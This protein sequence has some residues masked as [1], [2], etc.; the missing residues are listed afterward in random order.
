MPL[1]S[2]ILET[3]SLV[4]LLLRGLEA[5][6]GEESSIFVLMHRRGFEGGFAGTKLPPGSHFDGD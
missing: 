3:S 4:R 1:S 2:H 6:A 5:G